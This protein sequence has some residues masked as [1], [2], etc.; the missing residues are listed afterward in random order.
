MQEYYKTNRITEKYIDNQ[1][2]NKRR[3]DRKKKESQQFNIFKYKVKMNVM[4]LNCE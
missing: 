1:T 2:K 4:S 3:R